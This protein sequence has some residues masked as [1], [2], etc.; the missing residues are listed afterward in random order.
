MLTLLAAQAAL[1]AG[2]FST[3]D[4]FGDR[5]AFCSEGDIWLGDVDS[6]KATRLTSDAGVE[7][8]PRFSPDGKWIA[9]NAEY[10]G[11]RQAYVM[12]SSGGSPK[13]LAWLADYRSV[14]GWTADGKSIL[15]RTRGVPTGYQIHLVPAE[16]GAA[17]QLPFEF[18]S[19]A[20]YGSEP[21]EFTF[22]RF[23][24]W[25]MAWFRYIGGMQNQIWVQGANGKYRAITN[26]EGTCE[27]PVWMN[28]RVY[29]AREKEGQF[30]LMSVD[31]EGKKVSGHG[32]V[33]PF[34]IRNLQ[35]DGSRL[36]YEKGH[37]LELF[38]PKSGQF[39]LLKFEKQSDYLHRRPYRVAAEAHLNS[40]IL[41]PQNKR[42]FAESRGQIISLAV[43]EGEAKVW[44]AEPG[45]RL[46]LPI[47]SPDGKF[48]AYVSDST[49][50]QQVWIAQI[51]GSG[52]KALS[53]SKGRQIMNLRWSPDGKYLTFNDSRM[54]LNILDVA[55]GTQTEVARTSGSWGGV[56]HDI[57]PDSKWIIYAK[58][59]E[60]TSFNELYLY[61][62][63]T[64]KHTRISDGR[65]NN[66]IPGFSSDGKY[67]T[68]VSDRSLN[69]SWDAAFNQMNLGPM[70]VICL[71]PTR[72]NTPDPFALKDPDLPETPP[73]SKPEE[74]KID[75]EGLASRRIELPLAGNNYGDLKM[76][77]NR[78][79]FSSQ[80]QIQVY[81]LSARMAMAITPGGGFQLSPDGNQMLVAWPI[82][83]I[84]TGQPNVP[85][86]AGM[87]SL[88]QLSLSIEPE[89]EWKQMFWDAWRLLRDFFY[90]ENMHGLD[91]N[92]IGQKY[93]AML[94][95]VTSRNEL[96]ELIRWMQ[97]ELGSSHQYLDTGDIRDIKPRR[98]P[99]TLGIDVEPTT[100]GYYRIQ[101][102]VR[103]DT[104]RTNDRSP[105]ARPNLGVKEGDY[106]IEIA[107][108]PAKV[109][110]DI[111]A[112]LEGRAGQ[113][114]SVLINDKPS[115][116]GARRILVRPVA[117]EGRMRYL[118][119]VEKNRKYVEKKSG[120][121]I[122][123]LHM[124][125]MGGGDVQDFAKQYFA[126]RDKEAMIID[127][128]FNNGGNTQEVINR[129]L[130][131][132]LHAFFNQRD[133]EF[134]WSRQGDYFGGPL[135]CLINEFNI[136]CGEEF[137]DRFRDLKLGAII[138][139]R[140]MGGEVGSS[141]GW[142]LVDGGVVSV[143]N[144]GMYLP[145]GDWA[146]E[147]K[148]VSPDID[149]P[150]DPNAFI[151]GRDPQIDRAIEH[152]L[153][154]IKK[155]PKPPTKFPKDRDRVKVPD[156]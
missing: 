142:P 84:G 2:F 114:V 51:T 136:S 44:K 103:G 125:A 121:R 137:P 88:G 11:F 128:R 81:D 95:R 42:V 143:P 43:G 96:D 14:M 91:W 30:T 113:T 29:F 145:G 144:Y 146:I 46:Q 118:D 17:T 149:V 77:G 101:H 66:S 151:E 41:G 126:Q 116:V 62:V 61:E 20:D 85:P 102:I 134:P 15:I 80:G 104:F 92:A 78:V 87:V 33:S 150:S 49:G 68:F 23:N 105:L 108:V 122:G 73:P 83:V 94:P 112:G 58:A 3:P 69:A 100:S 153:A 139:R 28:S 129:V 72:A 22:T 86:Q 5:V 55:T 123:Y 89:K 50:E 34:E 56:P 1:Q 59:M 141:P 75:L 8:H 16:G 52:A 109:G 127:S 12:P 37:E 63:G 21:G 133:S 110:N 148:G 57:S 115:E 156:R 120:G 124:A 140:T 147:G 93:A 53:S 24:R 6:G 18:V 54:R 155:K 70:G 27:Y 106:L 107:G 67:I 98:A 82:R 138:G 7:S 38:D 32:P 64:K 40:A 97:S 119:W 76:V 99:A 45:V 71:L 90:V 152:L 132:R 131:A 74:F 47:P 13:R 4:V 31:R 10:D 39:K 79:F 9:F 65:A 60:R 25:Y 26:L 36:V 19:H 111:Y 135:A 48:M 154:E 117:G 130:A 35:S